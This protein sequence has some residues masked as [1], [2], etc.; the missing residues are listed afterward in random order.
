MFDVSCV[1]YCIDMSICTCEIMYITVACDLFMSSGETVSQMP[2][3][4]Q[5][6]VFCVC[7]VLMSL[8]VT[9][10]AILLA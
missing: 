10:T 4:I 7:L 2:V 6:L 9:N 8:G 5:S 1:T 3:Q